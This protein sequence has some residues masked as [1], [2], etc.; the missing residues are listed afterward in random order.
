MK[1]YFFAMILACLIFS[2]SE[3]CTS[4]ELPPEGLYGTPDIVDRFL[5][6]SALYIYTC[7][8]NALVYVTY[9]LA[10]ECSE[11]VFAKERRGFYERPPLPKPLGFNDE[12]SE[13]VDNDLDITLVFNCHERERKE[14]SY[15]LADYCSDW[16]LVD[17]AFS[18]YTPPPVPD[19]PSELPP[20]DDIR[21]ITRRENITVSYFWECYNNRSI[22]YTWRRLDYCSEWELET[23]ETAGGSCN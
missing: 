3:D 21:R 1:S 7:L 22:T 4:P 13:V 20:P 16:V 19:P 5:P 12:P 10:D 9:G 11:W 2:C 6:D 23:K 17:S 15:T 14:F 18:D 8:E